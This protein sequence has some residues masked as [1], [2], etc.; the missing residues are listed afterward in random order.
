MM[1][2]VFAEVLNLLLDH[3]TKMHN[4]LPGDKNNFAVFLDFLSNKFKPTGTK[5]LVIA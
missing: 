2:D 3:C 5:M 1:D 4:L